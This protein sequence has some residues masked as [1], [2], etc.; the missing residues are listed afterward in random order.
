LDGLNAQAETCHFAGLA[1]NFREQ[2]L[3]VMMDGVLEVRWE[4]EIKKEIPK[5]KCMV[6]YSYL[7]L[8]NVLLT[9]VN[10]VIDTFV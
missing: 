2:A 10:F 1:D 5:P 6:G 8:I 4:D 3:A 7:Y 9:H